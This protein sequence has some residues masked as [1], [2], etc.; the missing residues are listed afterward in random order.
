MSRERN[1][2]EKVVDI[3]AIRPFLNGG[4]DKRVRIGDE[5][6]HGER[7]ANHLIGM[8]KCIA[9]KKGDQVLEEKRINEEIAGKG[10]KK[11]AAA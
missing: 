1:K 11:K 4:P 7:Q 6:R 3:T 10:K 8:G 2:K 5:I 9:G